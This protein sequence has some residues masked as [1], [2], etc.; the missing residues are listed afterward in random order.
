MKFTRGRSSPSFSRPLV[1]PR[2]TVVPDGTH[3][4]FRNAP[5]RNFGSDSGVWVAVGP[6]LPAPVGLTWRDLALFGALAMLWG[7]IVSL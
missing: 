1:R 7:C 5:L 3:S 2:T 4:S 6:G